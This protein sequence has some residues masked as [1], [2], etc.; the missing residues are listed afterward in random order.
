[1]TT[2]QTSR[3]LQWHYFKHA[4]MYENRFYTTSLMIFLYCWL[5]NSKDCDSMVLKCLPREEGNVSCINLKTWMKRINDGHNLLS[6][7][8][9][10]DEVYFLSPGIWAYLVTCF[11]QENVTDVMLCLSQDHMF[12][13]SWSPEHLL[14]AV[15]L[16]CCRECG[17]RDARPALRWAATQMS[18]LDF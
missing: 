2:F 12:L 5:G 4:C 9:V 15:W 14:K 3:N 8:P 10:R 16:L 11:D 18:H 6:L 13:P 1:M 7:L 17:E